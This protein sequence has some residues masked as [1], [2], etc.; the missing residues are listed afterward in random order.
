MKYP[1]SLLP[2]AAA[3]VLAVPLA[4]SAQDA[5]AAPPARQ[6]DA[7]IPFANQGGVRDWRAKG[8]QQVYFQDS[9]GQWYRAKLM[10]YASDLPFVEFIGIDASPGGALDKW[11]AIYVKGQRYSFES[12]EKADGPPTR[13]AKKRDSAAAQETKAPPS[14]FTRMIR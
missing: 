5:P 3:V 11:S 8:S 7:S 10:S 6:A 12:F 4:A 9:H 14:N 1:R 2:L 13:K